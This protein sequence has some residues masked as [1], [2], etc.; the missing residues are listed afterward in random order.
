MRA[1]LISVD[2]VDARQVT[3]AWPRTKIEKTVKEGKPQVEISRGDSG[4]IYV[5]EDLQELEEFS[6]WAREQVP[7]KS[8]PVWE[9]KKLALTLSH[10]D[11]NEKYIFSKPTVF[12]QWLEEFRSN[13]RDSVDP[14]TPSD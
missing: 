11:T 13:I 9:N 2:L 14:S 6:V 7:L 1:N 3:T 5:F 10:G 4:L 8:V 12:V